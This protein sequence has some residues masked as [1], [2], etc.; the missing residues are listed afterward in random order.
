VPDSNTLLR[1]CKIANIVPDALEFIKVFLGRE[2]TIH[3]AYRRMG[4]TQI[5]D[6]LDAVSLLV[7]DCAE[8]MTFNTDIVRIPIMFLSYP[9][10]RLNFFTQLSVKEREPAI[11]DSSYSLYHC[12]RRAP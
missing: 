5:F 8:R 4:N 9:A 11:A 7:S 6:A 10:D 12:W 3:A 2:T 1:P